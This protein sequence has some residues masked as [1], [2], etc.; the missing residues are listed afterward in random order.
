MPTIPLA[1]RSMVQSGP[2]GIRRDAGAEGAPG[3]ALTAL[4][5]AIANAGGT[6]GEFAL[7]KQAQ[8]NRGI[9]AQEETVR[10]ETAAQIQSYIES[11]PDKPETWDKFQADTWKAYDQSRTQRMKSEKWGPALVNEDT[12]KAKEYQSQTGIHFRAAQDKAMIRQS[13][14]RLEANAQ[15]KLRAGDYEGFVQAYDQ[16]NMFPDQREDAVRRG[17]EEGTYKI[18]NNQLDAIRDMPPAQAIR[19]TEQFMASLKE[20]TD[21][22][23]FQNYE[24]DRGGLSL[25]GRVNLE[26]IAQARVREAQRTMDV[27]GRRIVG[28]LRVGRATTADVKAAMDAGE[29]DVE[30]ARAL[31][32]D[33]ALANEELTAKKAAKAQAVA[34]GQE[35]A[36]DVLRGDIFRRG[37]AGVREIDRQVALGEI[38]PDQGAKL[39][40]ELAQSSRAEQAMEKGDYTVISEKIRSRMASKMMGRNQPDDADYRRLQGDIIS[41]KVTKETRMKLMD[42]LFQLKLADLNDLQEEGPDDG[43]WMDRDITPQE[44]GLRRDLVENYRAMMP[45]LGDS[46]AGDLMFNQEAKIRTFFDTAKGGRTQAEVETFTKTQLLPEI[47]QAAGF[48]ALKTAFDF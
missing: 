23:R 3:R 19:A 31:A 12:L 4:G 21:D 24:F 1:S 17:L 43:R 33:I 22:G 14:A 10:M 25:G 30:T 47:Q 38:S 28:E 48:E 46:L 9:M 42:E 5:S 20:K 11:N 6:L 36:A 39:K 32:P 35:K 34:Q 45:A 15:T 27:T 41:S 40:A 37:E 16:M 44:R 18:A 13:N 2:A 8:V 26:S 29:L 7:Q